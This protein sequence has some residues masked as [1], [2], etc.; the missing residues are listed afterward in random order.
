MKTAFKY[1]PP[2]V[3]FLLSLCNLQAQQA[4]KAYFNSLFEDYSVGLM[5][6]HME[7]F[8]QNAEIDSVNRTPGEPIPMNCRSFMPTPLHKRML[9]EKIVPNAIGA[10][11]GDGLQ[12]YYMVEVPGKDGDKEIVLYRMQNHQLKAMLPLANHDC[13]SKRCLQL[14]SWLIDLNG[15]TQ[16]DLIQKRRVMRSNKKVKQKTFVYLMQQDGTFK[17]TKAENYKTRPYSMAPLSS[18]W[19]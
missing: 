16:L 14:D 8:P 12:N 11:R 6:V 19:D 3:L 9:E 15:D 10:V 1:L 13:N 7:A 4:T 2:F 17:R 18:P 5:H